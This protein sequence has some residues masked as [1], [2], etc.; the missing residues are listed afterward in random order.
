[1]SRRTQ[2]ERDRY[3]PRHLVAIVVSVIVLAAVLVVMFAD[4]AAD[5]VP[6]PTVT[7][8]TAGPATP[9]EEGP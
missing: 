9:Y 1:M 8:G 3:A 7:V 4:S 6:A 2:L 5:E